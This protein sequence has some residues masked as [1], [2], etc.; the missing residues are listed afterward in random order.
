MK[1]IQDTFSQHLLQ[2]FQQEE[3]QR[4]Q[5]GQIEG[6][7]HFMIQHRI[8]KTKEMRDYVILAEYTRLMALRRFKNK[9]V[10]IDALA[11]NFG[12][13]SSTVWTIIQKADTQESSAPLQPTE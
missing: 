13:P 4:D 1:P 2:A 7:V 12:L 8:L 6:L 5:T 10:T 11:L 9:S 3:G